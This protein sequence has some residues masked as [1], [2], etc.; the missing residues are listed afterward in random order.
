M[1]KEDTRRG[2]N[3]MSIE[4]EL[5]MVSGNVASS[6]YQM[7]EV[8]KEIS[9][10]LKRLEVRQMIGKHFHTENSGIVKVLGL[11]WDG[12]HV[13]CI[14]KNGEDLSLPI[15]SVLHEVPELKGVLHTGEKNGA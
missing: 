9:V 7:T 13:V 10:S 6:I 3:E 8:L 11:T 15:T 4:S 5:Q 1:L 14:G 2:G 12:G